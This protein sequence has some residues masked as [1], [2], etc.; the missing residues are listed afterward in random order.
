MSIV[1]VTIVGSISVM[2]AIDSSS[3]VCRVPG[4]VGDDSG[5]RRIVG[6]FNVS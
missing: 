3:A 1:I 5:G 2:V 4:G 6:A